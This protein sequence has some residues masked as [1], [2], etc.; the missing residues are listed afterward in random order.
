[1][2][3]KVFSVILAEFLQENEFS[4]SK[5]AKELGIHRCNVSDWLNNRAKPGYDMLKRMTKVFNVHANFWLGLD[6]NY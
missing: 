6:E 3:E 2:N 4:Q 5:F 1:M